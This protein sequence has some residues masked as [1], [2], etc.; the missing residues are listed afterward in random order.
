MELDMYAETDANEMGKRDD[1]NYSQCCGM[2]PRSLVADLKYECFKQGITQ[3]TALEQ[4]VKLWL[5]AQGV[6]ET[7]EVGANET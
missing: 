6:K 4:A 7:E 2:L 5:A 3:S 1:P